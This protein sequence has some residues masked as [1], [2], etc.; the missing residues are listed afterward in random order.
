MTRPAPPA[1]S[2][3]RNYDTAQPGRALQKDYDTGSG[4]ARGRL[5]RPGLKE[6]RYTALEEFQKGMTRACGLH[7][8]SKKNC[9]AAR[10]AG[11]IPKKIIG[12]VILDEVKN[13]F[14]SEMNVYYKS[15][16]ALNRR[17]L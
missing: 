2:P 16:R 15:L 10:P 3:K 7:G 13:E 1:D 17:I 8:F 11:G 4:P 6:L 9:G 12:K 14:K 5:G